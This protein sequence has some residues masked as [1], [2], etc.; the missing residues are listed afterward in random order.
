[1]LLLLRQQ[2]S[3]SS[4]ADH[5]R[6]AL[7]SIEINLATLISLAAVSLLLM[8]VLKILAK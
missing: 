1:M 4:F 7:V 2:S 8:G 3:G 6:D 5:Q